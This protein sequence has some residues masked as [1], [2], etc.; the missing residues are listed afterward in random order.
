MFMAALFAKTKTWKQ[1]KC[2]PIDEWIK[3][4]YTKT[5]NGVLLSHKKNK[6]MPFAAT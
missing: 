4:V 1:Q 5:P 6:I 3:N 2:P